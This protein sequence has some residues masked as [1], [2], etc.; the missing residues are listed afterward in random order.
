MTK[1]L[2]V[3]SSKKKN[4]APNTEFEISIYQ[5]IE[6]GKYEFVEIQEEK[7]LE[8]KIIEKIKEENGKDALFKDYKVLESKVYRTRNKMSRILQRVKEL[9]G[10]K[11]ECAKS[12][13]TVVT[14]QK[15]NEVEYLESRANKSNNDNIKEL[16]TY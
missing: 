7:E 8:S 2:K 11:Y 13:F 12:D 4:S 5:E 14:V 15:Q 16:S 9:N 10:E 6:E 1:L 3:L